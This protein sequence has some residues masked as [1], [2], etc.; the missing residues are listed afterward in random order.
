MVEEAAGASQSL[1][2]RAS[3]LAQ[4]VSV[5]RLERAQGF[6]SGQVQ[7]AGPARHAARLEAI[8]SERV[9]AAADVLSIV[10][11]LIVNAPLPPLFGLSIPAW[12]LIWLVILTFTLA[13][14]L[15]RREKHFR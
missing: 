4:S 6:S 10:P 3:S 1:L 8:D 9:I 15:I 11:P 13:I 12:S 2:D 7:Q 5:F 14:G